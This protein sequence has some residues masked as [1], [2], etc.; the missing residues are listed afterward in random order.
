MPLKTGGKLSSLYFFPYTAEC[1]FGNKK[2]VYTRLLE[3]S[4]VSHLNG[5]YIL[6]KGQ[7]IQ[8]SKVS[9]CNF[10]KLYLNN[11]KIYKLYCLNVLNIKY[12]CNTAKFLDMNMFLQ[13]FQNSRQSLILTAE[14]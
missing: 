5:I 3:T 4:Y 6:M 11:T 7:D 10:M 2:S 13:Y 9:D 12:Y 14:Y 8:F 1:Y